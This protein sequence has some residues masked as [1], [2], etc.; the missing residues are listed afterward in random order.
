MNGRPLKMWD[1]TF[2][3]L[4]IVKQ[5]QH[6]MNKSMFFAESVI[7]NIL[8]PGIVQPLIHG[9]RCVLIF[10]SFL[11]KHTQILEILNTYVTIYNIYNIAISA[12]RI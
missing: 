11:K 3:H 1:E 8:Y 2:G 10:S 5:S 7:S 9:Q 6:S 12:K 4:V